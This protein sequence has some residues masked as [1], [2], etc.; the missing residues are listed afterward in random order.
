MLYDA[1]VL[2]GGRSSRLSGTPKAGLVYRGE[3]LLG[4]TVAATAGAR[5]VVVVGELPARV[6]LPGHP[7][8]TREFPPFGGPAA[9]ISAG[10]AMLSA[11]ASTPGSQPSE[12]TLVLACDMPDIHRAVPLLLEAAPGHPDIDGV[13]AVD[14]D[15]RSQPLAALYR[16]SRLERALT[17]RRRTG[18]L[19][20]VSVR[21]LLENLR[22]EPVPVPPGSTHDVDTWADAVF[23][24]IAGPPASAMGDRGTIS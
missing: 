21:A 12:F 14:E 17:D 15:G 13:F 5:S 16:T 18:T 6:T 8:V 1:I 20:G 7:L 10:V 23:Y 2:G 24:G 3:T 4:R 9:A 22:L 11:L 19:D